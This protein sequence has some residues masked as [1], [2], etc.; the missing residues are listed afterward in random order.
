MQFSI[1]AGTPFKSG[2]STIRKNLIKKWSKEW[3]RMSREERGKACM[4]K[5]GSEREFLMMFFI[6]HSIAI[7]IGW[8]PYCPTSGN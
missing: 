7:N 8:S 4:M 2:C 5:L 6:L 1:D 3:L